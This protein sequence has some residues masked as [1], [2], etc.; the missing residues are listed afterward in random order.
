M[1][2]YEWTDLSQTYNSVLYDFCFRS[3]FAGNLCAILMGKMDF[4]DE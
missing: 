4:L 1:M 3:H 2:K